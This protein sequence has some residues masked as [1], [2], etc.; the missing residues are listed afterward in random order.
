MYVETTAMGD[1]ERLN[2]QRF[3]VEWRGAGRTRRVERGEMET[4]STDIESQISILDM[5]CVTSMYVI[6]LGCTL[7]HG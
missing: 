6:L 3:K 2:S 5:G 7:K 4:G 1:L